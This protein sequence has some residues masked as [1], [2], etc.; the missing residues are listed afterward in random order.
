MPIYCIDDGG[1]GSQTNTTHS[2]SVLD[3]AKAD[4]SIANLLA[5]DAAAL[6]TA[7][8]VIYFGDDHNDPNAVAA[9]TLTGPA[10]GGAVIL[11]SADRTQST[12]TYKK[13]TGNQISS[14]GGAFST[15]LDGS[16]ALIGISAASGAGFVHG[17]DANEV[18]LMRYCTV[19]LGHAGQFEV[20]SAFAIV[21]DL[22]I[23]CAADSG[24]TAVDVVSSSTN[25][26]RPLTDVTVVSGSNRTGQAFTSQ[27]VVLGADLSSCVDSGFDVV[28]TTTFFS[29]IANVKT[30]STYSLSD[31]GAGSVSITQLSNVGPTYDATQLLSWDGA[32]QV[33]STDDIYRTD[34]AKVEG[35]NCAWQ[36]RTDIVTTYIGELHYGSTPWMFGRVASTGS[37]TF[38][39]Y[40]TN[41]TADF[42]NS[43][44]WLEVV[45]LD[46]SGSPTIAVAS[47]R[48]EFPAAATT[49]PG[50][51]SR[52]DTTSTWVGAGPS[53]T[54]KQRLRVTAN[55]G[56]AGQFR[57]RVCVG[58]ASIGAARNFYVDP[59]VTVT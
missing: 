22:T 36:L 3:W 15:T 19:K 2:S 23:N 24:P 40:I 59:K 39:V 18:A 47:D 21:E 31:I 20:T 38:D 5:Y 37:R 1:D 43:Q 46:A 30:H 29:S 9:L 4:T 17:A 10:S 34:G 42:D 16:F 52:D 25:L 35:V 27:T 41:D 33:R 32:L 7:G 55:V 13:G 14:L 26:H 56:Q 54:Y 50:G 58:L 48:R 28:G 51:V 53:Y 49:S 12:P 8:N 6:T 11:V 45:Y 57:A 44:V